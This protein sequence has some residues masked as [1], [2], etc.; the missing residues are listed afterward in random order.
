MGEDRNTF[1][2]YTDGGS[3][4]NP[5]PAAAGFVLQDSAGEIVSR[6]GLYLGRATNNVAEY[7]AVIAGL[8]EATRR[9]AASLIIRSD[10]E[11]LVRQ[12]NGR[13]RVKSPDLKPLFEHARRLIGQI[14]KVKIEHI[15]REANTLADGLVNRALDAK[16]NIIPGAK[17]SA[18]GQAKPRPSGKSADQAE[19]SAPLSVPGPADSSADVVADWPPESFSAECATDGF[20]GCP[21]VVSAGGVWPFNGTTPAGLCIHAASAILLA[22]Q[23]SRPGTRSVL[24][25]CGK[26]GCKASFTIRLL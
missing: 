22:V 5:G 10:S 23:S 18:E 15:Y 19:P 7:R 26:P 2:L 4:G 1:V 6:A 12:L 3:R 16:A 21:G 20:E 17:A 9:E 11:L 24:A 8:E 25:R 13:Y 14:S